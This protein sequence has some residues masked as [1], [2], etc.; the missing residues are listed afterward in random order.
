MAP[1]EEN[2]QLLAQNREQR[3]QLREQQ[4]QQQRQ[5]VEQRRQ[6]NSQR[7]GVAPGVPPGMM[8]GEDPAMFGMEEDAGFVPPPRIIPGRGPVQPFQRV[9]RGA[10]AAAG[11]QGGMPLAAGRNNDVRMLA[12][13]SLIAHDDTVEPGKT[14]RYKVRYKL[15]NPI[16]K[17][18]RVAPQEL[19]APFALVSL[20]SAW[21]KPVTM[22]DKVEFFLAGLSSDNAKFDVFEWDAGRMKKNTVT[23]GPGDAIG[24]TGWSMVD[25]R[26][27]GRKAYGIVMN[28][29]GQIARRDPEKEKE[30]LRY[31]DLL[32]EVEFESNPQVGLR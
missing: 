13:I 5:L 32:D 7:R 14:Y 1:S 30:N 31:Q 23:A 11:Q 10:A 25:V 27:S 6:V 21:T 12:D 28:E 4:R 26:G 19:S 17:R 15:Y 22:R 20:D 29:T 2:E 8:M 3:R 9:P 16:Y 18:P 24:E